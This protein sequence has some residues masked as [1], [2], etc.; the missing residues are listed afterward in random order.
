MTKF[1]EQGYFV[2][3]PT[4]F[5]SEDGRKG[6]LCYSA[7]YTKA[8]FKVNPPGGIYSMCLHEFELL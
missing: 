2:N 7:N 3:I 5:I 6:W 1:G 4:K 8:Q